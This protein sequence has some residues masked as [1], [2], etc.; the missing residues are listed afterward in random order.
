VI[1]DNYGAHKHPTVRQWL[2][3]HE[4]FHFHFTPASCSWLTVS[5]RSP[6]SRP[7]SIASSTSTME[8]RTPHMDAAQTKSSSAVR[9]GNQALDSTTRYLPAA[10]A[11]RRWRALFFANNASSVMDRELES[12][13]LDAIDRNHLSQLTV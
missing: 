11:A 1:L 13:Q 5:A 12:A 3:H 2:A 4:R 9:R 8:S 10:F 7:P 6:T